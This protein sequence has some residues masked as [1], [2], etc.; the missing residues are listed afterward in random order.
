MFCTLY[1]LDLV[2]VDDKYIKKYYVQNCYRPW[3]QS[4]YKRTEEHYK[5]LVNYES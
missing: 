5:Q 4:K 3:I 1:G 2:E